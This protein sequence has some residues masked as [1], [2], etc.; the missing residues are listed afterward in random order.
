M[1]SVSLFGQEMFLSWFNFIGICPTLTNPFSATNLQYFDIRL[2]WLCVRT[3]ANKC[4]HLCNTNE[5]LSWLWYH[6]L[7]IWPRSLDL[8]EGV[9][10]DINVGLQKLKEFWWNLWVHVFVDLYTRKLYDNGSQTLLSNGWTI[11]RE[12][13]LW[14]HNCK[15]HL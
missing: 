12:I 13:F 5:S 15:G 7:S 4:M 10:W 14:V 11:K 1:Y 3:N 9:E 2:L 8:T 6:V